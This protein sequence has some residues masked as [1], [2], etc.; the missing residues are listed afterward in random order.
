[1]KASTSIVV[2]GLIVALAVLGY[3]WVQQ[4]AAKQE[5][6]AIEAAARLQMEG[7]ASVEADRQQAENELKWA[8]ED[9]AYWAQ[10]GKD[11][12]HPTSEDVME[13]RRRAAARKKL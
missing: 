1:M 6:A 11:Q 5:R 8:A 7:A 10:P 3:V 9:A 4:D 2:A 13:M 12:Q